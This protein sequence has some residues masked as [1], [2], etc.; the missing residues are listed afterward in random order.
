[1]FCRTL[2]QIFIAI[3][4]GAEFYSQK[5]NAKKNCEGGCQ[6]GRRREKIDRHKICILN[7]S[8][9]HEIL[10]WLTCCD[11]VGR[12]EVQTVGIMANLRDF[13]I[14]IHQELMC[15]KAHVIYHNERS[16]ISA[17]LHNT[18]SL[19][20]RVNESIRRGWIEML[21]FLRW[22]SSPSNESDEWCLARAQY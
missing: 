11:E 14:E 5:R 17:N 12:W 18:S 19:M 16:L 3:F 20:T 2:Q 9:R 4:T 15:E 22:A 10:C 8:L 6:K 21:F 1:M 13:L 7:E